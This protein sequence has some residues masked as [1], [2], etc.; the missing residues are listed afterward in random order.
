MWPL[1]GC[2]VLTPEGMGI[3]RALDF[4][5]HRRPDRA[6]WG[7]HAPGTLESSP[8]SLERLGRQGPR[9]S[10]CHCERRWTTQ[11]HSPRS[12]WDQPQPGGK[13]RPGLHMLRRTPSPRM[14]PQG[15]LTILESGFKFSPHLH[16]TSLRHPQFFASKDAQTYMYPPRGQG[17][18]GL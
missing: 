6:A 4:G 2:Y 14:R 12:A 15:V 17:R 5:G 16:T 10:C 1:S 13:F 8:L 9:V 7:P 11:P 18:R 3:T